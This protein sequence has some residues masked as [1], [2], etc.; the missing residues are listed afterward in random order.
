MYKTGQPAEDSLSFDS[1]R[2]SDLGRNFKV[3]AYTF[4]RKDYPLAVVNFT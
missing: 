2:G 3:T 4:L 1:P